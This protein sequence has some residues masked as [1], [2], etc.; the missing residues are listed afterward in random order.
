MYLRVKCQLAWSVAAAVL[1]DPYN[2]KLLS[3]PI[4][5]A[6]CFKAVISVLFSCARVAY[7]LDEHIFDYY[8]YVCSFILAKALHTLFKHKNLHRKNIILF[9]STTDTY[10]LCSFPQFELIR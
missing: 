7:R 9:F 6:F 4:N 5:V 3:T 1:G 2:K 10:L 8:T